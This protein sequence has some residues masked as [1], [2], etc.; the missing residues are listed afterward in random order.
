MCGA[1]I[2]DMTGVEEN[3]GIS[4]E[5]TESLS[6]RDQ[7]TQDN[8]KIPLKTIISVL[9]HWPLLRRRFST[10]VPGV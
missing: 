2:R 3:W 9:S 5:P 6:E 7:D 1:W 8:S 10:P 4:L